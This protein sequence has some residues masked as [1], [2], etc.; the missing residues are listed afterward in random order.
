MTGRRKVS[1]WTVNGRQPSSRT[2][3]TPPEPQPGTNGKQRGRPPNSPSL[4]VYR[5]GMN[6]HHRSRQR[7]RPVL[8]L[9]FHDTPR[10]I[11]DPGRR[12]AFYAC[13]L[14][15]LLLTLDIV[16][17][18]SVSLSY[19]ISSKFEIKYDAQSPPRISSWSGKRKPQHVFNTRL[20]PPPAYRL[21]SLVKAKQSRAY[22]ISPH[23]QTPRFRGSI[24]MSLYRGDSGQ[25]TARA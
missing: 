8:L 6:G 13:V 21:S 20:L 10:L 22:R 7:R 15:Y 12:S 24:C 18:P 9:S 14:H 11:P 17:P 4:T 5:N 25:E 2:S 23:Q 3:W 19:L 1:R 16:S